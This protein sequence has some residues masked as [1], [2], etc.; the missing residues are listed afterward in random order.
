VITLHDLLGQD[1]VRLSTAE[2]TGK[3]KGIAVRDGRVEQVGLSDDVIPASC[4][5]SFEGDVLTYDTPGPLD[6]ERFVSDCR[7]LQV[8]D[9][10]GDGLGT[11][12]D[13]EIAADGTIETI[14]L[15][16]KQTLAGSRLQVIGS[17]AAIVSLI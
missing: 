15:H 5:R 9:M 12:A 2:K 7:G 4:V 3:V 16:D 1:A 8:L 11:I 10:N 13:L 14:V 17:Y 6:G